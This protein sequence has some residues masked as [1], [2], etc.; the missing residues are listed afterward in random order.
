MA[1]GKFTLHE[2]LGA[3]GFGE[4]WKARDEQFGRWVALKIL[5]QD[6]VGRFLREAR[7]A[8]RLQDPGIVP[9]Y[10]IG[11]VDGRHFISMEFVDGSTLGARRLRPRDAAAALRSAALALHSAHEQGVVHR[12]VKPDNILIDAAGRVRVMDFGLAREVEGGSTLTASGMMVGTPAYMSPEQ[13]RGEIHAVDRRSDVYGLGATLYELL[14]RRPPFSGPDVLAIVARV[15]ED[16]PAPLTGIDRDLETI[17]M[18]CLEKEPARR[19]ATARALA[20]DLGR[21]LDGEAIRARRSGASYRLR[22][23]LGRR[24]L[25]LSVGL[26]LAVAIT[27]AG[28]IRLRTTGV[29]GDA[30]R[31][32]RLL[33]EKMRATGDTCLHAALDMRRV[34]NLAAMEAQARQVEEI[35]R[36]V[37]AQQPGLAEPPFQV[38]RLLR[39]QMRNREALERIDESLRRD[40]AF[41]PAL[42][43]RIVLRAQAYRVLVETLKADARL[44]K[45]DPVR[46][47][48]QQVVS[49]NAEARALRTA[50]LADLEALVKA[51]GIVDAGRVRCAQALCDWVSGRE[52]AALEALERAATVDAL[53]EA[54][55]LAAAIRSARDEHEDAIRVLDGAIRADA[56]Y[57]PYFEMRAMAQESRAQR[58]IGGG[59]DAADLRAG[60]LKDADRA[61][62]LAAGRVSAWT[63]RGHVRGGEAQVLAELHDL[64]A[65]EMYRAAIND[66]AKALELDPRDYEAR[67]GR[68]GARQNL[69]SY[70]A[71]AKRDVGTLHDDAIADF[72]AAIANQPGLFRA[73]SW[74]AIARSG[75]A[76]EL[77]ARGGDPREQFERSLSD[78]AEA[79]E[80]RPLDYLTWLEQAR[81]HQSF[82]EWLAGRGQDG[83]AMMREALRDC[84]AAVRIMPLDEQCWFRRG[85]LRMTL[86]VPAAPDPQEAARGAMSDFDEAIKLNPRSARSWLDRGGVQV[87][88]AV[89]LQAH[90]RPARDWFVA[91]CR[92]FDRAIAIDA[93]IAPGRQWRGN[94]RRALGFIDMRT[95]DP[96][97]WFQGADAD[98]VEALKET[99]HAEVW[100]D[101]AT[102]AAALADWQ[103]MHGGN[104]AAAYRAAIDAFT[105]VLR[106]DGRDA[107]SWRRRG[108][109][110]VNYAN[111]AAPAAEREALWSS[112]VTDFGRA[113]EL[114]RGDALAWQFRG[115]AHTQLAGADG[116]AERRAAIADYEEAI[117]LDARM[118]ASLKPLIEQ[119]R[120]ALK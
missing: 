54:V 114:N 34:A 11:E 108:A 44:L 100:S 82:G 78:F 20:D 5:R 62:T 33:L 86:V 101:K 37:E 113:I 93:R 120:A 4:V 27:V 90:G 70:L 59:R 57:V 97:E 8:A 32:K 49:D 103:R 18:T 96:T 17:V 45:D 58:Q 40:G 7:T 43:E 111:V 55:E 1:F 61:I 6:D 36:Q 79:L 107:E 53:E 116:D 117:R 106:R 23:F 10:E 76:H 21:Y 105:Q 98:Y 26:A 15:V 104:P 94:A 67:V 95:G 71:D 66:F 91:A 3:G 77:I 83:S 69:A 80:R 102:A 30:D 75:L 39:A 73:W 119:H 16:D 47:Q 63:T 50:I 2:R 14:A 51:P 112:A 52:T 42:Y 64:R 99:D 24:V 12:D 72:D 60:A 84:D 110:C 118:A 109:A 56:G 85:T 88:Y 28:V 74:R 65:E 19:Y 81:T 29:E 92:D 25:A 41:A 38:G 115:H 22:Q 89:W 87:N 48:W 13:A 31:A 68:G 35:C 9:I 46:T